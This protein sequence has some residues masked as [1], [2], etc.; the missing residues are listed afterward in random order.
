MAIY[1]WYD[2]L[3]IAFGICTVLFTIGASCG[4][5]DL[6]ANIFV[7]SRHPMLTM[8]SVWSYVVF[9][10]VDFISAYYPQRSCY[11]VILLETAGIVVGGLCAIARAYLLLYRHKLERQ[12]DTIAG[13]S[14]DVEL[15]KFANMSITSHRLLYF[16][17]LAA[18]VFILSQTCVLLTVYQQPATGCFTIVPC[19]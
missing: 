2:V 14:V 5:Y 18:T 8:C 17:M 10:C 13:T 9:A 4:L 7:R 6:R 11:A 1:D 19:M 15:V 12:K 16:I 3:L